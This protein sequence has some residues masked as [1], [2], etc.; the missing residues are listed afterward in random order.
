MTLLV[1]N[2]IVKLSSEVPVWLIDLSWLLHR[3]A[4]TYKFMTAG[5]GRPTGHIFGVIDSIKRIKKINFNSLV[6]LCV[7]GRPQRKDKSS[8]YKAGRPE[9]EFD[10]YQD[11]NLIKAF[12]FCIP[13]VYVAYQ[14]DK[15]ADDLMYSIAKQVKSKVYIYSGDDDLLQTIDDRINVVRSLIAPI[16][17]ISKDFVLTDERMLKKFRG[18]PVYALPFYRSIIGDKSDNIKGFERF[19]RELAANL[20]KDVLFQ[21]YNGETFTENLIPSLNLYKQGKKSSEVKYIDVLINEIDKFL[22][23]FDMIKLK[24][25]DINLERK[26]PNKEI[27]KK[28]AEAYQ[29]KSFGDIL[30]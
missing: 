20:A 7:D 5:G 1:N 21:C 26:V 15:E 24:V 23:N 18:T 17:M 14:E 30:C 29:L 22:F 28:K 9:L 10:F 4:H 16:K 19:P 8:D 12:S 25:F 6:V 11:V 2:Q 3:F 27:L 13:G